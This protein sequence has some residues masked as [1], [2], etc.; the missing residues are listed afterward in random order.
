[1]TAKVTDSGL[2]LLI[3]GETEAEVRLEILTR[4]GA[5]C[6]LVGLPSR[7]GSRWFATVTKPG[8]A[9]FVAASS[10]L[11]APAKCSIERIGLQVIVRGPTETTVREAIANLIT[12]GAKIV[13]PPECARGE[14]TAVLDA[15]R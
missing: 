15:P 3:A 11:T 5:G 12:G 8:D 2:T 13:A 7:V 14:W 9:G 10:G 6:R 1:M 4:E